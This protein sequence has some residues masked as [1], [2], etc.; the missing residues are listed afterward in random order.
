MELFWGQNAICTEAHAQAY[1]L[2]L[3]E[4]G[5]EIRVGHGRPQPLSEAS[6][7]EP[8]HPGHSC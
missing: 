3:G 4:G 1:A 5:R 2:H 7:L 8:R 6:P